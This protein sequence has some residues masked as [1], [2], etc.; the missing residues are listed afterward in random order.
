[1]LVYVDQIRAITVYAR[2]YKLGS[3]EMRKQQGAESSQRQVEYPSVSLQRPG[4]QIGMLQSLI[5]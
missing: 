1:M 3:T 2:M 4:L 5:L